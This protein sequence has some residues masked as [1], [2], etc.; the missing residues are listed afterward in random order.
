MVAVRRRDYL[1]YLVSGQSLVNG[2][3]IVSSVISGSAVLILAALTRGLLGL[4]KDFRKFMAEHVWL[5][6]TTL[7]TRDKVTVIMREL[8]IPMGNPPPDVPEGKSYDPRHGRYN[9]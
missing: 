2:G 5:I 8:G 6:A 1:A 7:W 9:P 3:E 4:R